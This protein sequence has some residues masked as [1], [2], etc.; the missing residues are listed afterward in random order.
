LVLTAALCSLAACS[1]S[2]AATSSPTGMCKAALPHKK[3]TSATATTVGAVRTLGGGPAGGSSITSDA[4]H[5]AP[6]SAAAA[7]CWVSTGADQWT[8]YAAG[9]GQKSVEVASYDGVSVAPTGAPA[10][11]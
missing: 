8:A 7:W 5:D 11:K 2:H 4:F 1:G 10:I 3:I 6:A 9:P